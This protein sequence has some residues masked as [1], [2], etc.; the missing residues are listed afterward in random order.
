MCW[1]DIELVGTHSGAMVAENCGV[2][3]DLIS[4][5]GSLNF[6]M[7]KILHPEPIAKRMIDREIEARNSKLRL[8]HREPRW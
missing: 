2:V 5:C 7:L 3:A 1:S 6:S 8:A 4:A